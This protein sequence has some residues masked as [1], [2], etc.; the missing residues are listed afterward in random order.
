[1]IG[2]V[3]FQ[4]QDTDLTLS[5]LLDEAIDDRERE[6]VT[7]WLLHNDPNL[8]QIVSSELFVL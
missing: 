5:T 1:M 2:I 3:E 7:Q 8:F 4:N 6:A